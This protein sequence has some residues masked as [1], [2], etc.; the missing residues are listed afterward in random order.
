MRGP[1]GTRADRGAIPGW[2][3]AAL[4]T[5]CLAACPA[6]GTENEGV[7]EVSEQGCG[8][9]I[10]TSGARFVP[11]FCR[12]EQISGGAECT[13]P[14]G[15]AG[16]Y[17]LTLK[18]DVPAPAAGGVASVTMFGI[19]SP[20]GASYRYDRA[21]GEREFEAELIGKNSVSHHLVRGFLTIDEEVEDRYAVSFDLTFSG[22]IAI[23]G[24]GTVPLVRVAAP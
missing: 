5:T 15:C 23:K 4:A 19:R 7:P 12:L 18:A 10:V 6:P 17:A 8:L 16:D 14:A 22:E 24:A 9:E 2:A 21:G 1:P 3:L 20:Y 11:S 13:D